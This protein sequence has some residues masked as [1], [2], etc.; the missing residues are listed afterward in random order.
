MGLVGTGCWFT[1]ALLLCNVRGV[2]GPP[3]TFAICLF[4]ELLDS[5]S[6]I[7]FFSKLKK[8]PLIYIYIYR[9]RERERERTTGTRP[10]HEKALLGL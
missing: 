1:L 10:L 2:V 8:T 7:L 3:W 9:E 6:F 4:L 5:I